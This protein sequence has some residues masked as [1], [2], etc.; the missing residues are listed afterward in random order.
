MFIKSI[1][2]LG[3]G[4]LL[5]LFAVILFGQALLGDI[6]AIILAIAELFIVAILF[7]V[8][9]DKMPEWLDRAWMQSIKIWF[10]CVFV[11]VLHQMNL[12]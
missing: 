3:I 5:G 6:F 7:T 8:D 11:W 2:K 10:I 4:L 9:E 1:I 12:F